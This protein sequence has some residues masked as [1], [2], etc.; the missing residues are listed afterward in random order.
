M[1][2][3]PALPYR[4]RHV[5]RTGE[6]PDSTLHTSVHEDLASSTILICAKGSVGNLFLSATDEPTGYVSD[7]SKKSDQSSI[8]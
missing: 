8:N 6:I 1:N 2:R 7:H 5:I 3:R 4:C